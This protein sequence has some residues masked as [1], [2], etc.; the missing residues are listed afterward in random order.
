MYSGSIFFA[1]SG[2]IIVALIFLAI[3]LAMELFPEAGGPNTMTA[4]LASPSTLG[5][6]P[7]GNPSSTQASCFDCIYKFSKALS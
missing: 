6:P 1:S 5:L 2:S 7:Y 4:R 3:G